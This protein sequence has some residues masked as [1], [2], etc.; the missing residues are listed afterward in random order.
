MGYDVVL[1][2]FIKVNKYVVNKS[3]YKLDTII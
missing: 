1:L 3:K 2:T